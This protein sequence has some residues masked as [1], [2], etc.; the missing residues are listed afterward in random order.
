[1][2]IFLNGTFQPVSQAAISVHDRGLLYGDGL[3]ETMRAMAGQPLW[4]REHLAR[5]TEAA[6]ALR[7]DL[8]AAF[9]WA[10]RLQELLRRNAL[11][12]GLAVIKILVTR[13]E[14]AELGLPPSDRPT[15]IIYARPYTPPSDQ[16]Y[17]RGWAVVSFPE[18]RTN[19]LSRYKSLNYLFCLA[20]R[21]YALD[22]GA[23]EALILE[24]DGLVAE[25]AA[26]AI[27]W[28]E[29]GQLFRAAASS[30]LPSVTLTVLGQ[31]L[32]LEGQAIKAAPVTVSRLQQAEAVWLANSLMGLMPVASLEGKA[33]P[34]SP[35]TADF[36][37]R[38][39]SWH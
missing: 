27:L 19:F 34:P 38:L 16:E 39:W 23:Q 3:F 21:Q 33:L 30:L 5:L 25:G 7:L 35:R 17:Q 8:P 9:P 31:A 6:A 26:T 1:M 36:Q 20:A 4:L 10:E 29:N 13:G 14:A 15:V 12:Q 32:A 2:E 37:Q 24:P 11:D 28:Q 18:R 22:R